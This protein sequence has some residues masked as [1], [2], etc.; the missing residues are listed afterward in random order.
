M[1]SSPEGRQEAAVAPVGVKALS[2]KL[3]SLQIGTEKR[4]DETTDMWYFELWHALGD[5]INVLSSSAPALPVTES[6]GCVFRDLNIPCRNVTCK[7]CHTADTAIAPAKPAMEVV[8]ATGIPFDLV[9]KVENRIAY[10]IALGST[11]RAIAEDVLQIAALQAPAT[12]DAQTEV[13]P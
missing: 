4:F 3:G 2:A 5:A 6:C 1:T 8:E 10:R 7:I 13:K 12:P 11:P 9:E